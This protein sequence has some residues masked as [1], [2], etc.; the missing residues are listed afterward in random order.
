MH[1]AKANDICKIKEKL[2]ECKKQKHM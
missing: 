2:M 1:R